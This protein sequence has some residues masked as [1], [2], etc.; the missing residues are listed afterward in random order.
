MA[1]H[2]GQ[3]HPVCVC[4]CVCVCLC[5][6]VWWGDGGGF[7]FGIGTFCSR[8]ALQPNVVCICMRICVFMRVCVYCSDRTYLY[9]RVYVCNECIAVRCLCGIYIH[10]CM[11]VVCLYYTHTRIDIHTAQVAQCLLLCLCMRICTYCIEV[12]YV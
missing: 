2:L 10:A 11:C 8:T 9:S 12:R 3:C 6:C 1:L 7:F 5:V 4:V